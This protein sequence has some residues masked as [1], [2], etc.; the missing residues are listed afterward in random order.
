LLY[1]APERFYSAPFMKLIN[2]INVSLFAVDE[3]HCIS[4]WGHDFRPSYLKLKKIIEIVGKPTVAAFTATATKEVRDDILVQ[5][6]I[7]NAEVVITGF[8]RQ[9]LK[10][11]AADLSEENKKLEMLR[12]LST[13]DGSGIVYVNT[14]KAVVSIA[15]LLNENG[16]PAIGYHGGMEKE[17][18]HSA[19][20]KWLDDEIRVV[21]ATNAFGMGIHLF[22]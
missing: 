2:Q 1:I 12:I 21:V 17:A 9:N 22:G 11:F 15:E 13:I 10:Y 4:Q 20:Q 19:Q 5:L 18:R 7:E 6:G 8:D 16:I 3:A 14:K